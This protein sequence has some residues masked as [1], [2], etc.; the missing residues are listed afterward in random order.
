MV[1]F[2]V[3]FWVRFWKWG[4][5]L[6]IINSFPKIQFPERP[7]SLFQDNVFNA[8]AP[9][10]AS[11]LIGGQLL[12]SV[13]NNTTVKYVSLISAQ[14]NL[15]SHQLGYVPSIYI[16]GIPNV[17]TRIWSPVT[18]SLN[19]SNVSSTQINLRC[20]ANCTVSIWVN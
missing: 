11:P 17:D 19:G 10:Q 4:S 2:L 7:I 9:I 12:T 18:A 20:S 8:F 13:V 6:S 16:A 5:F 1:R 14:D 15:I 3:A